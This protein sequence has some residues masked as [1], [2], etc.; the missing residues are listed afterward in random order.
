[1][2]RRRMEKRRGRLREFDKREKKI[3]E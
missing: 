3:S 1:M 2:G